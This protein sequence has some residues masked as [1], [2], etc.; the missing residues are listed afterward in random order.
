MTSDH[1]SQQIGNSYHF[2]HL[3]PEELAHLPPDELLQACLE[4]RHL[5]QT[6]MGVLSTPNVSLTERVIACDL[7]YSQALHLAKDQPA[8]ASEQVVYDIKQVSDRLGLRP[9]AIRA[10]YEQLAKRGAIHIDAR[11]L[12]GK[13]QQQLSLPLDAQHAD[14]RRE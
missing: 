5:L 1:P 14:K 7:L 2:L 13:R 10:A 6:L 3:T 12:P 9:S 11:S 8:D 4:Y